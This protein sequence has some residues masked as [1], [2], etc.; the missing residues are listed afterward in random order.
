MSSANTQRPLPAH[1]PQPMQ[2]RMG[3]APSWNTSDSMPQASSSR[4]TSASAVAVLPSFFGL[5]FTRSTF[6][7]GPLSMDMFPRRNYPTGAAAGR[8]SC[9]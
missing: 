3:P 7:D 4:A 9:H 2:S 6:M 1:P 8:A 5:P